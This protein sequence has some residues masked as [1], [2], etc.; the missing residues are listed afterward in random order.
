[1]IGET[2]QSIMNEQ[3]KN[4]LESY[5]IYLSMA[6]Y[7]HSENLDGMAHWMRIQAHEEMTHAMKFFDHIIDR[8]GTATLLD[9]K[10]LKT[11]W[12][13][14]LE[15]WKDA[16]DHEKFITGKIHGILNRVR[17]ENDYTAEPLLA[18]FVNEQIEE[19]A[20]TEKILRQMERIGDSR[21]GLF[22]L[23]RE[24]GTRIFPPGSPLDPAAYNAAT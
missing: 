6:S 15:A 17:A 10:Q 18:W 21:E 3:I 16:C 14:P 11:S 12:S 24:L 2:I 1:M 23:D 13:S 9:L 8:G 20:N 19:E 22:M 5:Y 4:E 7:F